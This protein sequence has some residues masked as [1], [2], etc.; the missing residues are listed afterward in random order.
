M[1]LVTGGAGFIGSHLVDLLL[2]E[3]WQVR[4]L[5]NLSTGKLANLPAAHER[6]DCMAGDIRDPAAVRRACAGVEI[7]F[8]L[9]AQ[10]SV[11]D[12][13]RDPRHTE[14]VNI[15]G[16][17]GLLGAAAAAGVHRLVFTS[18]CA[19]YGDD[20]SLPKQEEMRPMPQS[21]Y[22]VSKLAGETLGAGFAARGLSVVSLR[23][24]N[25]YGRRQSPHSDYAAV[26]PRFIQSGLQGTEPVIYGDGE[27]TR[28]FVCVHDVARA[29]LRAA[30]FTASASQPAI[31]NVGTGQQTSVNEL[32]RLVGRATGCT[33]PAAHAPTRTGEVR[34][35]FAST[36]R[37]REIL[38]FQPLLT[39][40]EGLTDMVTAQRLH[41]APHP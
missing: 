28:D 11:M 41:S 36:R 20:P 2:Q 8:H 30:L 13:I 19:V 17:A 22:A 37:A 3:G 15:G 33:L 39:L 21:P 1:A 31:F 23:C 38:G 5:D 6:L 10:V 25:V 14:E 29:N 7:V 34:H 26:V 27:Q 9:A 35:S 32:W 4:V 12:S 18:S 16:T 40:E 24:F